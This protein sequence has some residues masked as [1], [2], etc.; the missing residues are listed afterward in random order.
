MLESISLNRPEPD[1]E[2]KEE[3]FFG[4]NPDL[5]NDLMTQ[6]YKFVTLDQN[7]YCKIYSDSHS[8]ID[9][10][11][12]DKKIQVISYFIELNEK[13][14]DDKI[15]KS[16]DNSDLNDE[17][18]KYNKSQMQK[19]KNNLLV[20]QEGL[21]LKN[22]YLLQVSS[23]AENN[24]SNLVSFDNDSENNQDN[25]SELQI[26]QDNKIF[27][28]KRDKK[29]NILIKKI[30]NLFAKCF[31]F[32]QIKTQHVNTT[33]IDF[34]VLV[35]D[36][37]NIESKVIADFAYDAENNNQN[38]SNKVEGQDQ[39]YI[40]D[41]DERYLESNEHIEIKKDKATSIKAKIEFYEQLSS[42]TRSSTTHQTE[43]EKVL[44]LNI[45]TARGV[46]D[47]NFIKN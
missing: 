46:S 1:N 45:R 39:E 7:E 29:I 2:I 28:F 18:F 34:P 36:N 22:S 15:K 33:I 20:I 35:T 17:Y 30:R 12:D 38:I 37:I 23:I 6:L 5:F 14:I 19:L 27:C 42:S 24:G 10:L 31:R 32:L 9:N 40:N 11:D 13:E 43:E 3:I 16:F 47:F 25:R 4:I 44:R 26:N 41:T 8:P 21:K